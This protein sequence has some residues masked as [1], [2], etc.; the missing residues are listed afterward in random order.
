ML[1]LRGELMVWLGRPEEGVEWVQKAMQLD[2]LEANG[3]AHLLGR[4]LRAD[5]RYQDAIWAYKQVRKMR[6]Q[7]HAE[8]AACYAETGIDHEAAK[9][10]T[11]TLGLNPDF[12]TEAYIASLPYKSAAD[13]EHLRDS[14]HKAGLP[15]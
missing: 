2:P 14:L 9:Q 12:S 6:Y 5:R 15:D 4:A 13:R 10:K 7:H 3:Y 11:D 8:M 1:A